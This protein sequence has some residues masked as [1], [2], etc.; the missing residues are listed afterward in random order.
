[1][2]SPAKDEAPVAVAIAVEAPMP[3]RSGADGVRL[4]ATPT[5]AAQGTGK[6]SS[7]LCDWPSDLLTC[8]VALKLPAV[9]FAQNQRRAFPGTNGCEWLLR[10]IV[11]SV[12]VFMAVCFAIFIPMAFAYGDD[13]VDMDEEAVLF[14]IFGVA[15]IAMIAWLVTFV[16]GRRA[17]LRAKHGIAPSVVGDVC[18]HLFCHPCALA[19]EA[20]HI[21]FEE[22]RTL[23]AAAAVLE[24]AGQPAPEMARLAE[25]LPAYANSA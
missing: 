18:T 7:G 19:Q 23:A 16:G 5:Q 10:Y 9:L 24:A 20:R 13:F 15:G 25:P 1:M 22:R 4:L 14:P 6:F 3:Q 17:A 2:A 12:L 11:V 21:E 8:I